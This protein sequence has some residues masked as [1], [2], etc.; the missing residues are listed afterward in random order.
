MT[1]AQ[2]ETIKKLREGYKDNCE[3][4]S[5]WG[6]DKCA[7]GIYKSTKENDNNITLILTTISGI[8]DSM[9]PYYETTNILVE[10]NGN[11]LN[12]FDFFES[13]DILGYIES[14][15]KII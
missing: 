13:N 9:Q 12:L 2:I 8:S 10:P 3:K 1:E 6:I 4:F 15:K 5:S 14:L 7:F 11:S